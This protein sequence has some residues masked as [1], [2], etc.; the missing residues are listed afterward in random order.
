MAKVSVLEQL[1]LNSELK[2]TPLRK[3]VLEIF[4]ASTLPLSAY[5]VLA[6]LKKRR[7]TAEPPTVYRVIEYFVEKK[8]IHRIETSNKFV[9]CSHLDNFESS[10]HGVLFLCHECQRSYE[11]RDDEMLKVLSKFSKK[12]HLVIDE[13]LIEIKGT[14]ESCLHKKHNT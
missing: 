10:Y 4:L 8:L 12:H 11:I 3:D 7:P 13:S 1:S 2:M 6:L 9:C 14:C 5:E